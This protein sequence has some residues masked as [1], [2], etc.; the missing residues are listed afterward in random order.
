MRSQPVHCACVSDYEWQVRL[1]A[2]GMAERDNHPMPKSVT[3]PEAF[4]DV[5]AAAALDAI[6][7]PALIERVTRAERDLEIIR[8]A[9]GRAD[10]TAKNARHQAMTDEVASSESSLASILKGASTGRGPEAKD[11]HHPL[12]SASP[13]DVQQSETVGERGRSA[14]APSPP[15]RSGGNDAARAM[16]PA[17]SNGAK[18]PKSTGKLLALAA[19]MRVT[20]TA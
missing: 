4:Y 10:A 17:E 11:I 2:K 13:T 20:V 18:L 1:A 15:T 16:V 3:T 6:G 14:A 19:R 8:E 7:L 5:M 12:A 9:L